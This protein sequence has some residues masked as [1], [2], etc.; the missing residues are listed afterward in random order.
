MVASFPVFLGYP[1]AL[2]L[3][4]LSTPLM[5][6]WP[7]GWFRRASAVMSALTEWSAPASASVVSLLVMVVVVMVNMLN[8]CFIA[9]WFY[10]G[11]IGELRRGGKGLGLEMGVDYLHRDVIVCYNGLG[12]S[13]VGRWELLLKQWRDD[14]SIGK[15]VAERMADWGVSKGNGLLLGLDY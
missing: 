7:E 4:M 11:Y 6:W 1:A 14:G 9:W 5:G 8:L 12:L 15:G 10:W 2:A 13:R 3:L